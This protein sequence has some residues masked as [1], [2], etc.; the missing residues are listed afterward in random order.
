MSPNEECVVIRLSLLREALLFRVSRWVRR[1]ELVLTCALPS[2]HSDVPLVVP[3][4]DAKAVL[5]TETWLHP[6]LLS[7]IRFMPM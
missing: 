4:Q 3:R 2:G 6:D 1:Q 7:V 5:I